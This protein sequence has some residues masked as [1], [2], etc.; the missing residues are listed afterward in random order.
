MEKYLDDNSK[1]KVNLTND[2]FSFSSP[3]M[4]RKSGITHFSRVLFIGKKER[5]NF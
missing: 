1:V 3:E 2:F 4:Y 5:Q